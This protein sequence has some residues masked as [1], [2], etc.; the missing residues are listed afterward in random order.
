MASDNPFDDDY[1]A[2]EPAPAATLGA[3]P[4]PD[5]PAAPAAPKPAAK[6]R[7]KAASAPAGPPPEVVPATV[8]DLDS[9]LDDFGLSGV[10]KPAKPDG[11]SPDLWGIFPDVTAE[12]YYLDPCPEVSLS[13]SGITR[14]VDETPF[15]FAYHNER[16]NPGRAAELVKDT[17]AKR[18]GDVVHQLALGK[19]KGYAVGAK[20][21]KA[22]QSNDAK[23]FKAAAEE[24]GLVPIH[25]HQFEE[26][27]RIAAV[28]R[29]RI[30]R[31]L[32][33]ASYQTEVPFWFQVTTKAGP[34]WMRGMMDVWSEEVATI[35]DPKIT[36]RLYDGRNGDKVTRHMVDM[37]WDRQAALYTV[38]VGQILPALAGR[39]RFFDLMVKP[40]PP[41]TS[42]MV[43]PERYW[44]ASSMWDVEDACELFGAC[45]YA[46]DWPAFPDQVQYLPG[47]SWEMKRREEKHNPEGAR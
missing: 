3:Q 22:W 2:P 32:D 33:G 5:E 14:L 47:P 25:H 12:A 8:D 15:D 7:A 4:F 41:Y 27:K 17:L 30:K 23:A 29:E 36:P 24:K 10:A 40:E 21:W 9:F 11:M 34:I 37:A 39:I 26:A 19:G 46:G 45:L 43:A 28:V 42:R 44:K 18:R 1:V 16:L 35:I 6:P 38:G 20:A 13:N 31:A